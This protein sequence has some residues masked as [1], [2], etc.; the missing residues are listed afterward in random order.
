MNKIIKN[1]IQSSLLITAVFVFILVSVPFS[2]V[3]AWA[4]AYQTSYT[5]TTITTWTE[6]KYCRNYIVS[7]CI[8]CRKSSGYFRVCGGGCPRGSSYHGGVYYECIS[9]DWHCYNGGICIGRCPYTITHTST[10]STTYYYCNYIDRVTAWSA[11]SNGVQVA[12]AVHWAQR[13]WGGSCENVPLTNVCCTPVNASLSGWSG[14]SVACGG[15]TQ[16]RTCSGADCGGDG[17][18]GGAVLS[19]DCNTQPCCTP[20]TAS[21]G[22][23]GTTSAPYPETACKSTTSL[24]ATGEPSAVTLSGNSYSWSCDGTC[25]GGSGTTATCSASKIDLPCGSANNTKLCSAPTVNLCPSEATA[26]AVSGAGPWNWTCSCEGATASCQAEKQEPECFTYSENCSV[27]CGGGTKRIGR[28]VKCV[29][30]NLNTTYTNAACN[31][32]PCPPGYR[33]VTPW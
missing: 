11:C 12:T 13:D 33:E 31:S 10:T 30:T 19:Q 18:C 20:T 24:C 16:N 28:C 2:R 23:A 26:S 4:D 3:A 27:S 7:R 5:D 6:T 14:C 8:V 22:S 9:G 32:Q 17:T 29:G 21:C 25:G 1:I 15:G